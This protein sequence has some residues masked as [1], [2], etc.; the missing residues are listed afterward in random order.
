M[1]L[2]DLAARRR[3]APRGWSLRPT[4]ELGAGCSTEALGRPYG[5]VRRGEDLVEVAEPVANAAPA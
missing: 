5:S 1:R 4:S 2:A 3:F